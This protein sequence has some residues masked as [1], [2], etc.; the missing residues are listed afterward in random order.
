MKTNYF[1]FILIFG[2][3]FGACKQEESL[4]KYMAKSWETNY[5]KIEMPTFENTD[6]LNVFEDKFDNNPI[7]VAQSKYNLDGTF[8]AWFLT[9][10]NQKILETDGTWNVVGDSLQVSFFYNNKE[11]KVS[12]KITKTEEGFMGESK[13]DWDNDGVADDFL[14][15]KTKEIKT[16]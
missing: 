8:T 6:S 15:M 9:N 5:L 12:Y 3:L 1:F 10:S 16:E 2:M 14:T 13:Y 11:M 7:Q 4:E